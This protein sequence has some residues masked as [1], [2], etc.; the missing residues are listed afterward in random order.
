MAFDDGCN[1]D[2]DGI[3]DLRPYS[4]KLAIAAV[5][6][7]SVLR[8]PSGL[9]EAILCSL[10]FALPQE[11]HERMVED[12][13]AGRWR[14]PVRHSVARWQV[15]LDIMTMSWEREVSARN[16]ILRYLIPD[17]SPQGGYNFFCCRE[18]QICVPR[19][20][21]APERRVACDV[22]TI[23][24]RLPLPVSTL[25]Y[26]R[27]S[28]PHKVRNIIFSSLLLVPPTESAFEE[29]RRSVRSFVSDQGTER[30]ICDVAAVG[31][32]IPGN[33]IETLDSLDRGD[34]PLHT[35][36]EAY[37]FPYALQVD[38]VCHV[39][40]NALEGALTLAG[41]WGDF[42]KD[43]RALTG[44][45]GNRDLR[46]LFVETC[47]PPAKRAYAKLFA[48]FPH[49]LVS[50][51]WE[52]M[53]HVLEALVPRVPLLLEYFSI[54]S[55]QAG[56]SEIEPVLF[57]AVAKAL[58]TPHLL[59]TC[60]VFRIV[61]SNVNSAVGWLEGCPCHESLLKEAGSDAKRCKRLREEGVVGGRCPWKGRRLAEL[62]FHGPDVIVSKLR[63]CSSPFL[64][65][66]YYV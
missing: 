19:S 44:F 47:I 66:S 37:L 53:E 2:D 21:A 22:G 58:A 48:H 40:F 41:V 11:E 55:M 56:G 35:N 1:L 4:A 28:L 10:E 25:G 13:E 18:D 54:E 30:K 8:A 3:L 23:F 61:C 64:Q 65:A 15:R 63:D 27:A 16:F 33:V 39:M 32:F 57:A 9:K 12:L 31:A 5:K 59:A 42:E 36:S 43:L 20:L 34:V 50:W 38:D 62:A 60:E 26:G 29:W 24:R 46:V 52:H 7:N 45:L 51:R 17:S 14:I 6:I 49:R